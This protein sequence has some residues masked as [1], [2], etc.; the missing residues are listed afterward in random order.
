VLSS[1]RSPS[2]CDGYGVSVGAIVVG[3]VR[4]GRD[5]EGTGSTGTP[6]TIPLLSMRDVPRSDR[7]GALV[8]GIMTVLGVMVGDGII[9]GRESLGTWPRGSIVWNYTLGPYFIFC[10]CFPW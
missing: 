10:S 6:A 7:N 2:S 3:S 8:S 9:V 5:V 1:T 4:T